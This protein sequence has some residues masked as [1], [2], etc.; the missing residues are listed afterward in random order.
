MLKLCDIFH[1][2]T[3]KVV[4]TLALSP[5]LRLMTL[6]PVWLLLSCSSYS[7]KATTNPSTCTSTVLVRLSASCCKC[8]F[9]QLWG[10]ELE[11]KTQTRR[12]K[13]HRIQIKVDLTF[14]FSFFFKQ[15]L[16]G[17]LPCCASWFLSNFH[18]K[19]SLK[20]PPTLMCIF[21]L[22]LKYTLLR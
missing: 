22:S 21:H 14:F 9:L 7:Q 17:N 15:Y 10:F 16:T 3:F 19:I 5:V 11:M 8:S 1:H 18:I 2:N 12:V 6:S 13:N 4:D 20:K